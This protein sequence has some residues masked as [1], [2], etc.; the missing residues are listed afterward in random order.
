MYDVYLPSLKK[1]IYRVHYVQSLSKNLC[2]KIRYDACYSKFEHI[3]SIRDAENTSI[4]FNLEI[5][6]DHLGNRRT[7][8]IKR[9]M[10]QSVDQDLNGT[11][12]FHSHFSDDSRQDASTTPTY[13]I[14]ML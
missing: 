9:C 1:Y 11:I 10:I 4:N 13:M 2:G 5:Q 12:Q 8:S 3:S 6:Y 14:D 7:L